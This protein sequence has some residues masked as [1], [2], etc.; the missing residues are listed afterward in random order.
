[1]QEIVLLQATNLMCTVLGVV[2]L[3]NRVNSPL[4]YGVARP[5][6]LC[7]LLNLEL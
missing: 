3:P 2:V 4:V 1:M 6:V 5:V 7:R